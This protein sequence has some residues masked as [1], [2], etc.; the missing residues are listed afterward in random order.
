MLIGKGTHLL[1]HNK[2][3]VELALAPMS[4]IL[5]TSPFYYVISS[6]S[7][8]LLHSFVFRSGSLLMSLTLAPWKIAGMRTIV[9]S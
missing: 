6:K 3:V 4:K 2:L 5:S 7:N 1:S 9:D 8:D